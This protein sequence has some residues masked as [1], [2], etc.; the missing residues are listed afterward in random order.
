[1]CPI[2]HNNHQINRILKIFYDY[3]GVYFYVCIQIIDMHMFFLKIMQLII[4]DNYFYSNFIIIIKF[5]V[6]FSKLLYI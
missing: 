3:I 6:M 4:H 1:M 2:N 5:N